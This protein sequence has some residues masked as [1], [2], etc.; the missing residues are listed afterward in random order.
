[1]VN[2]PGGSPPATGGCEKRAALPTGGRHGVVS[3]PE[4]ATP[5][6]P[7]CRL[8]ARVAYAGGESY[9]FRNSAGSPSTSRGS[10]G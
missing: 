4:Q 5:G 9:T 3:A 1:M 8:L 10:T 2:L 7:V 6:V